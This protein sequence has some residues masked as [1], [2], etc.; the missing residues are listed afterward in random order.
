MP[1]PFLIAAAAVEGVIKIVQA[2]KQKKEAAQNE[3]QNMAP[4]EYQKSRRVYWMLRLFWKKLASLGMPALPGI[5]SSNEGYKTGILPIRL[6]QR[7]TGGRVLDTIGT[8]NQQANDAKLN[9]EATN[10]VKCSRK[11]LANYV[12]Q[13]GNQG[14][15]ENQIW[16]FNN[17]QKFQENAAAI[18]SLKTASQANTNSALSGLLG[19]RSNIIRNNR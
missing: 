10:A 16:Q 18:R 6:Q 9:L 11:I 4:V 7:E 17:A 5:C 15:W 13:L 2:E 1:I 19:N 14:Q 12:Q 8:T 3:A